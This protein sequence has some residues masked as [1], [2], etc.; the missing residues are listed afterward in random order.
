MFKKRALLA[1]LVAIIVIGSTTFGILM[2]LDRRDYRVF[3]ENQYQRSLYEASEDVDTIQVALSKVPVTSSPKDSLLLF[4]Q[5][6]RSASDAQDKLTSLPISN[7]AVSNTSKFLSQVGDFCYALLKVNN[8]GQN[9]SKQDLNTVEKLRNYS[10]YL[11]VQL[12]GLQN[13]LSEGNIDWGEIK[14]K[15]RGLLQRTAQNPVDLKFERIS[16]EMQQYPTL[17]YDGPF[18]EN[19]LT[20]EPRILSEKKV[21]ADEAKQRAISLIGKDKVKSIKL[22]GTKTN[23]RV[24]SY[25]FTVGI[26]G[27]KDAD[28]SIDMSI[29]GGRVVYMLDP[30]DVG[31]EKISPQQAIKAGAEYLKSHGYSNMIPT[32]S[33]KYD[34]VLIVN[35]VS[36]QDKVIVYPDQIKL[37]IALDNGGIVGIESMHYLIAHYNRRIPNPRITSNDAR[38][39]VSGN[40]KIK[41]IR[42]TLIPMESQREVLC[43]EFMGEYNGERFL[44]YINAQDGTQERILKLLQTPNGEMTM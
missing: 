29:N 17:I 30:R 11:S 18:A 28:V 26:N 6:W 35:Y 27:R 36:V 43:Y 8:S 13:S 23:E 5:I 20:I 10:S 9:L 38:K 42:L 19:V 25:S 21:S 44:V 15:G 40:L 2:Y 37:K 41:N 33:L 16:A 31:N 34:S 39:N 14:S 12:N 3:L 32:Y 7:T 24:P 22:I 4:S 1:I